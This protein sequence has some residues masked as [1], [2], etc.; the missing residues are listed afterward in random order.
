[1]GSLEKREKRKEKREKKIGR[2]TKRKKRKCQER[3]PR[4]ECQEENAKSNNHQPTNHHVPFLNV[5]VDER[6]ARAAQTGHACQ[7]QS[8]V[9]GHDSSSFAVRVALFARCTHKFAVDGDHVSGPKHGG[10]RHRL[11][12]GLSAEAHGGDTGAGKD[13]GGWGGWVGWVGG[14]V[15]G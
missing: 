9:F 4:R 14:W 6:F 5:I 2:R 13:T 3:M 15:G 7:S 12:T 11:E 8:G 10:E 1:M